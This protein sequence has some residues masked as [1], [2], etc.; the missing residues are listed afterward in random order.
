MRKVSRQPLGAAAKRHLGAEPDPRIRAVGPGVSPED[1]VVAAVLQHVDDSVD[2]PARID[3]R[4]GRSVGGSG[5]G[6]RGQTRADACGREEACRCRRR[7]THELS[8]GEPSWIHRSPLGGHMLPVIRRPTTSHRGRRKVRG[9]ARAPIGHPVGPAPLSAGRRHGV[10]IAGSRGT[11][12]SHR[13]QV[14]PAAPSTPSLRGREHSDRG[15]RRVARA[16]R[17][18]SCLDARRDDRPHRVDGQGVESHRRR[19]DRRPRRCHPLLV[20]ARVLSPRWADAELAGRA[21]RLR[22]RRLMDRRNATSVSWRRR[23]RRDGRLGD[24][25]TARCDDPVRGVGRVVPWL[26]AD[27]SVPRTTWKWLLAGLASAWRRGSSR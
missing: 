22:R 15:S 19:G 7:A 25:T 8:P 3:A 11:S 13:S 12:P 2:R 10:P 21:A 26:M 9:D 1:V 23:V 27:R 6:A 20:V 5:F 17:R 16:P 4:R 18:R 14:D 24:A